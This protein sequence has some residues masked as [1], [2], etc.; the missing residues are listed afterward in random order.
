VS[1][2]RREPIRQAIK[3]GWSASLTRGSHVKLTHKSGAI[4][5]CSGT[6]STRRAGAELLSDLARALRRK[7]L[8]TELRAQAPGKRD[9]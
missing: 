4:V 7:N 6:P 5:Y 3:A 1:P 8:V 2:L 9:K